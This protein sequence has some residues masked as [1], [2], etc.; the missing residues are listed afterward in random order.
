MFCGLGNDGVAPVV[1]VTVR[2]KRAYGGESTV[3]TC[4]K[5]AVER[6]G[7]RSILSSIRASVVML[8]GRAG[9]QMRDR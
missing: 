2:V 7:I 9:R 4:M 5:V 6:S 8:M 3:G 1:V